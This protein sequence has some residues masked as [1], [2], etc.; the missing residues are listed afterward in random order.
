MPVF[1]RVLRPRRICDI[2]DLFVPCINL[3]TYL[4]TYR[5]T[6]IQTH[7]RAI[8]YRALSIYDMLS[9]AKNGKNWDFSRPY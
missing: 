1:R 4:L 8:A 5:Q 9:R 6:A 3:F 2:Y 7:G